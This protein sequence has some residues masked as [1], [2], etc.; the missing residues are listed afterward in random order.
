MASVF[1]ASRPIV[2]LG[3]RNGWVD[4]YFYLAMSLVIAGVVAWGFSHTAMDNLIRATPPRPVLLWVHAM[5]FSSWVVFYMVQ[6]ALVRT[7]NVRIH[8]TLGW[9]G[10]GLG[11]TMAVVGIW[12][13][14]VMGHF[15]LIVEQQAG[16]PVS[17]LGGFTDMLEFGVLLTL[18]ILWRRRPALHRPLLFTATC[19]LLGAAFARFD[20]VYVRHLQSLCVDGVI[21]LGVARDLVVDGRVNKV[22]RW[23]LPVLAAVQLWVVYTVIGNVAWWQQL[24]L[25]LMG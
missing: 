4:R 6:T 22:Y 5:A 12:V 9:F 11:A 7:H 3:G 20:G 8:R 24:S 2:K 19:V 15:D 14:L 13:S 10:T 18:G 16:A 25:R 23:A 1:V 21:G 17:E